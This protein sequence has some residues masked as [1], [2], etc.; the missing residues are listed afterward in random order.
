MHNDRC[1]AERFK[2]DLQPSLE[3][4]KDQILALEAELD[5]PAQAG[6]VMKI[7]D[8]AKLVRRAMLDRLDQEIKKPQMKAGWVACSRGLH[9]FGGSKPLIGR[10]LGSWGRAEA[11][12]P[13][14][15]AASL[16]PAAGIGAGRRT[17]AD[18]S[19]Q[20]V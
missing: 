20:E 9:V 12:R 4:F 16:C 18:A 1:Q 15:R 14:S 11:K 17:S 5:Q 2:A 3:S 6:N 19:A 7:L 10:R 13:P 8:G